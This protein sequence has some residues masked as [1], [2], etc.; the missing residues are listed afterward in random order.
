MQCL[1]YAA[2]AIDLA[3]RGLEAGFVERLAAARSNVASEGDGRQVWT[4][5]VAVGRRDAGHVLAHVAVQALLDPAR[6]GHAP[7]EPDARV[8]SWDLATLERFERRSP[9]GEVTVVAAL[10]EAVST[11]TGAV[12]VL[13]EVGRRDR[14]EPARIGGAV[15]EAPDPAAWRALVARL[16]EAGA[17]LSADELIAA[18]AL[19]GPGRPLELG[20]LLHAEGLPLPAPLLELATAALRH[21][22]HDV[23]AAATPDVVALDEVR[24]D[25]RALGVELETPQLVLAAGAALRE[26]VA[27]VALAPDDADALTTAAS[28]ATLATRLQGRVER[29]HAQ[30]T[31]WE[32][33][34][35]HRARWAAAAAAGDAGAGQ[36]LASLDE[37]CAALGLAPA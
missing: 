23:V 26:L 4:R 30:N 9:D 7:V 10:V 29:W 32:L 33:R 37:L 24:R 16:A 1:A 2:R 6:P 8:L 13:A 18:L 5:R 35:R 15:V 20:A 22:V 25:A 21:R 31:A 28:A 17:T 11:T 34:L 19:L 14:R 36:H 12:V 3:D 27:R